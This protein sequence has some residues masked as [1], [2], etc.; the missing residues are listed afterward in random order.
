MDRCHPENL[1]KALNSIKRYSNLHLV[2]HNFKDI[3][4]QKAIY[5]AYHGSPKE[6]RF[7]DGNLTGNVLITKILIAHVTKVV[8][9]V[10]HLGSRILSFLC[11]RGIRK[12][13]ISYKKFVKESS[14]TI[15]LSETCGSLRLSCND[16]STGQIN[17]IN[18]FMLRSSMM[19][20]TKK[21]I[22]C[23]SESINF[24]TE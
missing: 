4:V 24:A 9:D 11:L 23:N 7:I 8:V 20:T 18:I 22:R 6:V 21:E 2:I 13:D 15:Y 19:T 14:R 10:N 5:M 1:E 3:A 12:L 16:Y 17:E